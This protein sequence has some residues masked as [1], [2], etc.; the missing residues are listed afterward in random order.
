[1]LFFR[2][3]GYLAS[4]PLSNVLLAQKAAIGYALEPYGPL[5]LFTGTTFVVAAGGALGKISKT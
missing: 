4:G 2:G 1:M 5:I 3:V